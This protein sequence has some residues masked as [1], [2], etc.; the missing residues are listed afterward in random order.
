MSQPLRVLFVEDSAED[1]ALLV[2]ELERADYAVTFERVQTRETLTAALALPTWDLIVCDYS[3]PGFNGMDALALWKERD[4]DIPFIFVSGNIGEDIAVAAMKGGAHDYLL[5][6]NLQRFIPAVER[7]LR[8][9]EVR[10]S[11][12]Q[13]EEQLRKLSSAVEQAASCIWITNRDGVI[14]YVNPNF[15]RTTGYT[16]AEALGRTPRLLK[17]GRHDPAFYALLWQTILSGEVFYAEFVNRRK[18]GELY[19]SEQTITP[20]KDLRGHITHFVATGRDITERKQAEATLRAAEE[21]YRTLAEAAQDAIFVL[22]RHLRYQYVNTFAAQQFGRT[23]SELIGHPLREVFPPQ[24]VLDLQRNLTEV[25][26]TGQ[27][28]YGEDKLLLGGREL[29]FSTRL[30]PLRNPAG[31][32]EAVM[33]IA[34][35]ITEHKQMEEQ[36][37]HAQK[38]DAIGQLAGGVAHD[39]NN[40]LTVIQGFSQLVLSDPRLEAAHREHLAMVYSAAERAASLTRQLLAFSRKQAMQQHPFDLNGLV[41]GVAKMLRR[42]IGE[43]IALELQLLA[44][45]CPVLADEGMLE[46]VLVNLAVNARDAMPR[47]GQLVVRTNVLTVDDTHV[48]RSPEAR[49]GEFVCLT[50][51]DTG[52]GM[53][54]EVLGRIFEPFFTTKEAGKGTGL[55]LATVYG[56]VKQHEGWVEIES[57]PGAGSTF[58]V[59]LPSA[60]ATAR[61]LETRPAEPEIHGGRETILLVEDDEVVR[62]LARTVL[63][64]LGYRVL[65]ADSG[66]A[67]LRLW[68][69]QAHAVD[70]LLTDLIMPG[71]MT[72]H[73]L[74]T[75]LQAERPALNVI[76]TSGY[77]PDFAR[78]GFP[79][80]AGLTY[81]Q[82]PYRP[83]ELARAV[84]ECLDHPAGR[85]RS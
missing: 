76:Y 68:Q 64:R 63:E 11:R 37:R 35:D 33:G 2:R 43:D 3:M 79:L 30:V 51:R 6:G 77:S 53:T 45:P 44:E 83:R 82:K 47:G 38:M 12:R 4:L 74:A 62:A 21:K 70:L 23:P 41:N 54:P 57:A 73:E 59:C 58:H 34:R 19:H 84:R 13:A 69:Q 78:F 71:G 28:H 18:N 9:A 66:D 31:Q 49:L 10:R 67:A 81:L 16:S 20:I 60:R 42:L 75:K 27:S 7:E 17:S 24:V 36:L 39:F 8:E 25:F 26:A 40:L 32:V 55:G 48:A 72:G 65:E 5:K 29:W 61:E 56:I 85:G 15:E 50:V 1:A 80:E 46:Q 22:D 14:E 52:C